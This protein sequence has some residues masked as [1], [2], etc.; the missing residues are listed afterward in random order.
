MFFEG[1]R[2]TGENRGSRS[3]IIQESITIHI[4]KFN[5]R[6]FEKF[7]EKEGYKVKD[8]DVDTR[9]RKK[10]GMPTKKVVF[11]FE[12]GQKLEIVFAFEGKDAMGF[13][14]T[15]K[16]DGRK[17]PIKQA[18]SKDPQTVKTLKKIVKF[19]EK[20]APAATK[21][22]KVMATKAELK[23]EPNKKVSKTI[24]AKVKEAT[25]RNLELESA[26]SDATEELKTIE[27]RGQELN[28]RHGE[29]MTKL[30][31]LEAKNKELE[32]EFNNLNQAA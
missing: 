29:L 7:F 19:L 26:L 12:N 30:D 14:Y 1:I 20:S 25:E 32:N 13:A 15:A 21:R 10:D 4:N 8:I 28:N 24:V 27:D 17:V 5:K 11:T 2:T 31:E 16:V 22:K 6:A 18:G 9:T 3:M 23:T